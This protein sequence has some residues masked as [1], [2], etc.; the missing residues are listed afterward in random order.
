M[1]RPSHRVV[2]E[3]DEEGQTLAAIVR[4]AVEGLSWNRAKELC[5]TGRV[6]VDGTVEFD[7]TR[8]LEPDQVVEVVPTGQKR[9]STPL[10][11]E[12]ILHVDT[13]VVVV[14]KPAGVS[15]V[16]YDESE[17]DTLADRLHEHLRQKTPLGIVQRL[18]KDTTGILVFA[19]TRAARKHLENQFRAHS[20]E[21]RYLA[22][23]TGHAEAKTHESHLVPNRGDHKRG[24]WR[25][26]GRPP[27]TAKRA[28]TH[29][30]VLERFEEATLVACTLE[31][32]RQHQIRIHLAEAGTPLV[33]ER[34]YARRG[35]A[36]VKASRPMLHAERLGFRHPASNALMQFH[37]PPPE[38]FEAVLR[39]LRS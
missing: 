35:R 2:V 22:I 4:G 36:T 14:R 20:V 23:T 33:G 1:S 12:A 38:D 6:S 8:R 28:V 7:A 21:R 19:R 18:D 24:S 3:P 9:R 37:D 26:S 39:S 17:R 11:R 13:H 31:T 29:V 5:R 27:R 32:G 15:S 10:D 16:P 34:V 25:G 30:E